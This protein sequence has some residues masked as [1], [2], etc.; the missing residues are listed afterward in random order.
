MALKKL[1]VVRHGSYSCVS[2]GL[3]EEGRTEVT[4]LA[5]ELMPLLNGCKIALLSSTALRAKETAGIL[6]AR[7]GD[8]KF[9]ETGY[10][11]SGSGTLRGIEK[12]E[13]LR[14]VAEKS[15]EYDVIILSTHFEF[16]NEFPS[17][18]GE[19][20]GFKIEEKFDS[21]YGTARIVDVSTGEVT[22]LEPATA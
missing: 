7:F 5:E 17:V 2:D 15:E 22:Y 11:C 8:L 13:V 4:V 14:L 9:E 21:C 18:W 19:E 12:K 1:I 10:L 16:I 20:H 6:A 3:T